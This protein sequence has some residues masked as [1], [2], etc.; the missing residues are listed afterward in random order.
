M[1]ET[2]LKSIYLIIAF[3]FL[4]FGLI[5]LLIPVLP[6][7]PFLILSSFFFTK[8]SK[9]FNKWFVSTKLYK[10]NL[11]SFVQ[12]KTMTIKTKV[13]ILSLATSILILAIY[14]VNNLYARAVMVAVIVIKYYYFIFKIKIITVNKLP[15]EQQ[16]EIMRSK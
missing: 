14:L 12:S 13:R 6:T 16:K 15:L 1:K 10:N 3:L 2:I 8:G 11:Q 9:R 7:T 5:G 4:L